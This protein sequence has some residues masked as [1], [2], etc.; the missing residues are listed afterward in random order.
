MTHYR[1]GS[2]WRGLVSKVITWSLIPASLSSEPSASKASLC[3][4][5][6]SMTASSATS[7]RIF[8]AMSP[9]AVTSDFR[10]TAQDDFTSATIEVRS[11]E[12]TSELQSLMRISDA[13]FCLQQTQKKTNKTDTLT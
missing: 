9:S 13:V 10:I 4:L 2:S 1:Y 12:H 8:F 6:V 7:G 3:F 5:P 11:E